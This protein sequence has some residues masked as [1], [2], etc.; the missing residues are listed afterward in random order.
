MS[1]L[2]TPEKLDDEGFE[3]AELQAVEFIDKF[4]SYLNLYEAL[5]AASEKFSRKVIQKLLEL[6]T[7]DLVHLDY[8]KLFSRTG[9]FVPYE[10]RVLSCLL[11]SLKSPIK[12]GK[13]RVD[14][15]AMLVAAYPDLKPWQLRSEKFGINSR[16]WEKLSVAHM[17][18]VEDEDIFFYY[19]Y[20]SQLMENSHMARSDI[21]LVNEWCFLSVTDHLTSQVPKRRQN[22]INVASGDKDDKTLEFA[23][24]VIQLI[25]FSNDIKEYSLSLKLANEIICSS[26][27]T[28]D[29]LTEL[30]KSMQ[31]VSLDC[32]GSTKSVENPLFD[33]EL[34][35][36][37]LELLKSIATSSSQIVRDSID[38]TTELGIILDQCKQQEEDAIPKE[39]KL[40]SLV[41]SIVPST[42][43]LTTLSNRYVEHLSKKIIISTLRVCLEKGSEEGS[44]NEISSALINLRRIRPQK[45]PSKKEIT[46]APGIW[47][48]VKSGT[49]VIN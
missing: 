24:D 48:K 40:V 17:K 38:V 14:M 25:E 49:A 10:S 43:T 1:L 18:H 5:N 44:A 37:I 35:T 39:E 23:R 29:V 32:L 47:E 9:N 46:N 12:E 31:R 36:D 2:D 4:G 22:F 34:M 45:Q 3:K 11:A 30:M 27:H 28:S 15:L 21:S 26:Y 7:H 20:L 6:A 16:C 13:A 8:M 41:A 33:V 19:D 42:V